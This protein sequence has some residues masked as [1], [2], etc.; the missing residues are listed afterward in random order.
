M[1]VVFHVCR[2]A[3]LTHIIENVRK[4]YQLTRRQNL[5]MKHTETMK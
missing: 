3:C 1:R 5:E 4:T 2:F